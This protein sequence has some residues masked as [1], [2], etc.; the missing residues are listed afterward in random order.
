M[1]VALIVIFLLVYWLR[2][3]ERVEGSIEY[4]AERDRVPLELVFVLYLVR[5]GIIFLTTIGW[6][7]S[8]FL[9]QPQNLFAGVSWVEYF[10]Y[11]IGW[12]LIAYVVVSSLMILQVS[13]WSMFGPAALETWSWL[14]LWAIPVMI[15][16]AFVVLAPLNL[17][18][19]TLLETSLAGALS[20]VAG[21]VNYVPV[22]VIMGIYNAAVIL[23][24]VMRMPTSGT[25][26]YRAMF[27]FFRESRAADVQVIRARGRQGIPTRLPV[28]PA[29]A[30][31]QPIGLPDA[32]SDL[33][34]LG[35]GA[36]Q[37]ARFLVRN[38]QG[39]YALSPDYRQYANIGDQEDVIIDL[40]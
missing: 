20:M 21:K 2:P 14:S 16:I 37:F 13:V 33:K 27:S 26:M 10:A 7:S 39:G 4:Q 8:I 1:F 11:W 32:R 19:T 30:T 36:Q 34:R 6:P 18:M 12:A 28:L 23:N 25:I 5:V 3:L 35:R 31:Y 29:G 9:T 17:A 40:K 38:E 22:L 15:L 24:G